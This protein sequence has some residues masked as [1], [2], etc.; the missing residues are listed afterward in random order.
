MW[1]ARNR[2]EK[3]CLTSTKDYLHIPPIP[4]TRPIARRPHIHTGTCGTCAQEL[5]APWGGQADLLVCDMN[6]FPS[7]MAKV[8]TPVDRPSG[9]V[10][11][12]LPAA[13][14]EC[15]MLHSTPMLTVWCMGG[16]RL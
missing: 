8:E 14:P 13:T 10:R 7:R 6:M 5:L 1:V 4:Y 9:S 16:R 15:N 12:V 11:P 3:P 2:R